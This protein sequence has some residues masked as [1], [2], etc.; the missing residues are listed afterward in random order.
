MLDFHQRFESIHPFQDGNGR[1]GR[2]IMFKEC[3]N[4]DIVPF[5]KRA[6]ARLVAE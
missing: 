3:L 6:E 2:L 5:I 1:V 4:H